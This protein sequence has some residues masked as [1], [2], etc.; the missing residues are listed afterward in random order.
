MLHD[1]MI[2]CPVT[3]LT[4]PTGVQLSEDVFA[5]ALFMNVKAICPHCEGEHRWNKEDAFLQEVKREAYERYNKA[6]DEEASGLL[7][8]NEYG[9]PEKNYYVNEF[10][11]IQVSAPWY[12]PEFHRM[13]TQVDWNDLEVS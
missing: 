12:G 11:R 1:V 8:M 9:N 3:Q 4:L 10:G 6:L 7:L 5:T 13:C 2:T